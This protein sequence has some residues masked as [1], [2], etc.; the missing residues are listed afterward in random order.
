M[1]SPAFDSGMAKAVESARTK[2]ASA[3]PSGSAKKRERSAAEQ[4]PAREL[5]KTA[6]AAPFPDFY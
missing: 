4:F 1:R 6:I 5:A 2:R 3:S